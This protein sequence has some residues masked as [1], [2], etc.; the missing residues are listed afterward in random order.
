MSSKYEMLATRWKRGYITKETLRGWVALNTKRPGSGI[1]A[2]EYAEITGEPYYIEAATAAELDSM[3][4][5]QLK[6]YAADR[7][8][9]LAGLTLKA[10]I[11][12]AIKTAEGLEEV[13]A[14]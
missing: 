14:E 1:T 13:A 4:V 7:G 12:A 11:L 3:T 10:D 5:A 2:A 6:E 9:S 8:I